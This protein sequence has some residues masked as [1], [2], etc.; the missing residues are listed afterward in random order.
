M[1]SDGTVELIPPSVE[2]AEEA[3]QEEK[4]WKAPEEDQTVAGLLK[5]EGETSSVVV[6]WIRLPGTGEWNYAH[7]LEYCL[8][9]DKRLAAWQM[10]PIV[11][12]SVFGGPKKGGVAR[13]LMLVVPRWDAVSYTHLDVYKRQQITR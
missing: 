8:S 1:V 10:A 2:D 6:A 7:K 11:H 3:L 4:N 5:F 9:P 13:K 12:S